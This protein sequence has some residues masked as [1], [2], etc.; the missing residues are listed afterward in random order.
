MRQLRKHFPKNPEGLC[1]ILHTKA[2]GGPPGHG[3][4]EHKFAAFTEEAYALI[5]AQP[6]LNED[7]WAGPLAPI[8]KPTGEPR[9]IRIFE[10]GSLHAREFPLPLRFRRMELPGH[11]GAVTVGRILGETIGPDENGDDCLYGWG[12][13]LD[14]AIIPE[15]KEA[16]YLVEQGVAG[17]SLDP[18]GRIRGT[19]NPETGADHT[20]EYTYGGATLVAIPAFTATRLYNLTDGEWPD[21]D[22]DM[23]PGSYITADSDCGC[24]SVLP[25]NGALEQTMHPISATYAVN[26]DG[27]RGLPLAPRQAPFD[28]DDATK[29]ISQWARVAAEGTDIG[30]LRQA[31]LWRDQSKPETDPTSYRLPVGDIV[32]GRLT[33]VFHAIY[34]A[35]ALLSG[36]HGGL[37]DIPDNEKAQLRSVISAIYPELAKA[38]NDSS[39]AAPW[40]KPASVQAREDAGVQGKEFAM[41]D[42]PKEPYGD[43]QYA[44]PGYQQDGKKRYPLDTE[45]HIRAAWTYINQADNAAQ[46]KPEQLKAIKVKIAAAMKRIGADVANPPSAK[47]PMAKSKPSNEGSDSDFDYSLTS[48]Y[49][50][51][52]PASWFDNPGLTEKTPVVVEPDGRIYGHLAAWNECHRDVSQRSCVL[53]PRSRKEYAPFHL[54]QVF[55]A[56]GDRLAVGKIV[57]D[58]RHADISLGYTAT[59]IH[60]DN[61]GDEVA[62]VRAGEDEFGIWV[63]GSLVPEATPAKAAKL[64]RSPL[65]GDWRA[66]D[67]NLELTAALAV[68]VPAFPVYSMN[69]EEQTALVAAGQVF[70]IETEE[71]EGNWDMPEDD[72]D[73]EDRA[74]EFRILLE[75]DD[76][77]AQWQRAT[78]LAALYAA[79][80]QE[81]PAVPGEDPVY[82]MA[83]MTARQAGGVF[84]VL[85]EPEGGPED[86]S[87]DPGAAVPEGAASSTG[88]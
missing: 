54:G 86:G 70:P 43:V 30:K 58:T 68:N 81:P 36:A 13:W 48:T 29:R 80:G 37:P 66:V 77:I 19:V 52:P 62:V 88:A 56:E 59:A 28:N 9:M 35:A 44:D 34:A 65:S 15:V 83:A 31:F 46:Y 55:T 57:M 14:E 45:E 32:N 41:A 71:A 1:N 84:T 69:G 47:K 21:D 63:A 76:Q 4:A 11:Q 50:L 60:Y 67:G 49:P 12:D 6:V 25:E 7:L 24:N 78:E 85:E 18:G 73:Q 61:T 22:P 3:S 20:T 10:P 53:A 39:I 38:F 8:G 26:E 75:E 42:N 82:G 51:E 2:T 79:D 27:W 16:K 17:A 87:D 72:Q 33:M 40:D 64:R 5:A 23:D 74:W